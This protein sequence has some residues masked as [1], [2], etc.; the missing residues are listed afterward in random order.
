M[1]M[2]TVQLQVRISVKFQVKVLGEGS[3]LGLCSG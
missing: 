1:V 3:S 2:M